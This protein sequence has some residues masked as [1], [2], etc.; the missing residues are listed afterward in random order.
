MR[1][2]A[3]SFG[4]GHVL[5]ILLMA[6][7]GAGTCQASTLEKN[8]VRVLIDVS[9]SMRQN[10]PDNL[11]RPALR[12]LAG[13]LQPGTRAGVWTFAR[14]TNNL[15]PVGEVD[16]PWKKRAQSL[17][18]QI[19]SPGQFT[20]IED[21]LDKAS[22]DWKGEP[23]THARHLVLLTDGMVD[24][25]KQP[26]DNAGSRERILDTLLPRLQAAG[27]Q[28][29]T[30]A[31]SERADHDLMQRLAAETGGW[32]QQVAQADE[33]QRVFLR[34]FEKVGSPDTVPLEDN[35]FVVDGSVNEATVLLFSKPDSPP[36]VLLSPS[37]ESYKDS[38]LPAGIA[39]SRDQGYDMISIASPQKGEWTLQADVDPDNRV[40]IVTDLKLQTSEVPTHI[41]SAEQTRIEANLSNRGKLVSRQAFLRLIEV[42]AESMGAAGMQP[43][44]LNDLGE[45]GD[46]KAGDGRYA[47]RFGEQQ[48]GQEVE[49]LIAVDSPTFMR[50]KR[51]RLVVHEPI[52]AAV[53]ESPDG[54]LLSASVQSA[55]MQPGS[56]VTAWQQ[57]A[58]G[59]RTPLLLRESEG[60]DWV[61]PLKD[62]VATTF[63]EISG[64]TR[65]GNLIEHTVG[66]L[67]LAGVEPPPAVVET[68]PVIEVAAVPEPPV[69]PPA[70]KDVAQE[71]AEPEEGSWLMPAIM[72]GV[73]NLILL[74]GA[75]VWFF[76]KRRRGGGADELDLEQLVEVQVSVP[77]SGDS[78]AREDAA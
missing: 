28:V 4:A 13:L 69:E 67:M 18:K 57:D 66:P 3:N 72:F 74:T 45:N 76:L 55:V 71:P 8:D 29:H 44:P 34:M 64:T 35:L 78:Q 32:Y 20:N 54:P 10:D 1:I 49:L 25:S 21:V 60:G 23:T 5:I 63:V 77:D 19:A 30:I 42:R 6:L 9:G 47:M 41:A 27:V 37:G 15:V 22:A 75:G 53:A 16:A 12:M 24:V 26:A 40:M 50:E 31:L 36:A 61:A 58:S 48:A 14:Q 38:D 59:T 51:F 68:P 73:F 2:T 46:E 70:E 56:S 62:L 65:L 7:V 52:E 11:R 43:V 39:W 17:S 33:L